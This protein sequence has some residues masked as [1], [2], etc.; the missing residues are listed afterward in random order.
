MM[1]TRESC[2]RRAFLT[3]LLL[4]TWALAQSDANAETSELDL[5]LLDDWT[6]HND[7][8]FVREHFP[9]PSV[10]SA[11]WTLS[12]GGAVA[13]PVEIP[14]DDLIAQPRKS[15]LVTLECAENP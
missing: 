12:I 15:V 5:S 4:H 9:T 2:S 3:G 1:G 14:Y 11:G 13:N 6:T 7:L 10:S 8:F